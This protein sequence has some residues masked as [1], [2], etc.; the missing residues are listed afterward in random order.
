MIENFLAIEAALLQRIQSGIQGLAAVGSYLTLTSLQHGALV[1]PSVWVGYGG[2]QPEGEPM[3]GG[4]VQ[5][6][7]QVW[8][9]TLVVQADND[10]GGASVRNTAGPLLTKILQLLMGWKPG[11]NFRPFELIHAPEPDYGDGVGMFH[12]SFACSI[13]LSNR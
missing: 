3:A 8:H 7:R 2:Y 12:L 9:V 4:K 10:P 11:E 5:Q 1:F 6:I 13:P